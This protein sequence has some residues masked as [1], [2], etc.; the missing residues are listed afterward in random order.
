M[1]DPSINAFIISQIANTPENTVTAEEIKP[2]NPVDITRETFRL[3]LPDR[4]CAMSDV[5]QASSS[6]SAAETVQPASSSALTDIDLSM[7]SNKQPQGANFLMGNANFDLPSPHLQPL[8]GFP[9]NRGSHNTSSS[10]ASQQR[11]ASPHLTTV[12]FRIP[13]T[14]QSSPMRLLDIFLQFLPP[15]VLETI[16]NSYPDSHWSYTSGAT[17]GKVLG[18]K[19]NMRGLYTYLAVYI[20]SIGLLGDEKDEAKAEE[21][22]GEEEGAAQKR[23]LR[24]SIKDCLDYFKNKF[25]SHHGYDDNIS[26]LT[27]MSMIYQPRSTVIQTASSG[28]TATQLRNQQLEQ[29]ISASITAN[30]IAATTANQATTAATTSV[31]DGADVAAST[32][33]SALNTSSTVPTTSLSTLPSNANMPFLLDT[34]HSLLANATPNLIHITGLPAHIPMTPSHVFNSSNHILL[35]QAVQLGHSISITPLPGPTPL[36]SDRILPGYDLI[37]KIWSRFHIRDQ[38]YSLIGQKFC[39]F[40]DVPNDELCCNEYIVQFPGHNNSGTIQFVNHRTTDK[41]GLY[42]F[43]CHMMLSNPFDSLPNP[44]TNVPSTYLL[45]GNIFFSNPKQGRLPPLQQKL[46][47]W[48]HIFQQ[49]KQANNKLRLLLNFNTIHEEHVGSLETQNIPFTAMMNPNKCHRLNQILHGRSGKLRQRGDYSAIYRHDQKAIFYSYWDSDSNIGKKTY[50]S[51]LY[52]SLDTGRGMY[53]ALLVVENQHQTIHSIQRLQEQHQKQMT[54]AAAAAAAAAAASTMINGFD[55]PYYGPKGQMLRDVKQSFGMEE[56]NQHLF[57]S[58]RF[59]TTFADEMHQRKC[60]HKTGGKSKLGQD[61][62]VHKL[63]VACILHNTFAAFHQLHTHVQSS[64]FYDK[65][66]QLSDEMFLYALTL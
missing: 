53:P 40:I 20:R 1:L 61:G 29:A 10:S 8:G 11:Q 52:T 25:L 58:F 33:S 48:M 49:F 39:D 34:S 15:D 51:N 4:S 19:A 21:D 62:Q 28:D 45:Y 54:V 60:C 24:K 3:A 7:A 37:E 42:F 12:K 65:C 30:N 59:H 63:I 66:F 17:T 5:A 36:R 32:S 13:E 56:L 23:P 27:S 55:G 47:D 46:D 22:E 2:W 57:Q 38:F 16:W 44:N 50:F 35:Q 41:I 6:S 9:S 18:G 64:S 26:T 43:S 31:G 14:N